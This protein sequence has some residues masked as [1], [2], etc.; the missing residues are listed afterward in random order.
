MVQENQNQFV[1]AIFDNILFA[2]LGNIRYVQ[3]FSHEKEFSYAILGGMARSNTLVQR[4][5]DFLGSPVTILDSHEATIR[6]LLILCDIADGLIN[7]ASDLSDRLNSLSILHVVSP[8]PE[9]KTKLEQKY[10]VW[11]KILNKK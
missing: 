8:R 2:V 11:Q 4:F 1:G 10:R 3:E 9:M 5:A 7:S 6:G